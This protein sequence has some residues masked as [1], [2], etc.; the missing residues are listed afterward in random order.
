VPH[1]GHFF[2]NPNHI[3]APGIP[4]KYRFEIFHLQS[5]Q[6]IES[7]YRDRNAKINIGIAAMNI[8]LAKNKLI[9]TTMLM[10]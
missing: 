8:L 6:R 9:K 5:G 7:S 10:T 1:R 2:G 3:K 4:R